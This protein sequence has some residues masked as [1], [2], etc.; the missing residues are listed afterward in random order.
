VWYPS[1][2][3]DL[4]QI[5]KETNLMTSDDL[6]NVKEQLKIE[7]HACLYVRLENCALFLFSMKKACSR[8]SEK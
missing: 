6:A 5:D 1:E 7:K 3:S 8:S 2:K 4:K